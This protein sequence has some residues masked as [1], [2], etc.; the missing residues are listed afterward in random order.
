MARCEPQFDEDFIIKGNDETKLRRLLADA[1]LH[2]LI[3]AQPTLL[4][5]L[6]AIWQASL[7]LMPM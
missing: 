3:S 7:G 2:E 6:S 5:W 1:R 4:F